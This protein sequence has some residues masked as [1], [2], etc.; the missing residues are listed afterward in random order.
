MSIHPLMVVPDD[1]RDFLIVVHIRKDPLTNRRMLFHLTALL[2]RESAFFF[3]ESWSESN[4]S[5]VVDQTAQMC[6]L[7][8][9]LRET[10]SGHDVARI[11]RDCCR[12][13]RGVAVARVE[14]GD[15]GRRKRQVCAFK[16]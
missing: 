7:L 16:P 14:R 9:I 4:L 13:A 11:D 10:H 3:K 12:V 2:K 8:L 1:L 5:N 6:Q 15:Q